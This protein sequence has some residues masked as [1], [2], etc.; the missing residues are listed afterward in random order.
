MKKYLS[1]CLIV[2]MILTLSIC[3]VFAD[4]SEVRVYKYPYSPGSK[5]WAQYETKK[6]MLDVCQIPENQYTNMSTN[7][8]LESVLKY[9]F[10]NDFIAY[11]SVK[12]ACENMCRS[13][14]A[15]NELLSRPD[16]TEVL[17]DRYANTEVMS[18]NPTVNNYK[19]FLL[20][21]TIEFL[22][23]CDRLIN[24]E[25]N[26]EASELYNEL[27]STKCREKSETGLYSGM[28]EIPS[29]FKEDTPTRDPI[30]GSIWVLQPYGTILTPN[31]S[32][33]PYVYVKSP[34]FS[35]AE[36]YSI[37][38]DFDSAYPMATRIYGCTV[39]YNC[40]SFAW[41][42][43]S[44]YNPYWILN[45]PTIYYTDG[46]YSPYYGTPYNGIRGMY[47]GDHSA[48]YTGEQYF[49]ANYVESKWGSG[50]VYYHTEGY[51]P[52]YGPISM[53]ERN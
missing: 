35:P 18:E 39:K 9:P 46:S 32:N 23:E 19:Q 4:E 21:T 24:G 36:A 33:V 2:V 41:Y 25:Y 22:I 15:F 16:V 37:N 1:V 45:A 34:D 53:Y 52:Y 50:G 10:I 6:E 28:L 5:E 17:L 40:H 44:P 47:S 7:T 12:Y 20:P 3:S 26:F 13:F 43:A 42:Y 38:H 14:D 30:P 27:H 49:G 8:L 48:I 31:N 51:C 29:M 11:N